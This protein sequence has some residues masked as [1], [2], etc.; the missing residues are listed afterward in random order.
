MF[1]GAFFTFWEAAI[2]LTLYKPAL[3]ELWF[4]QKLCEDPE[5]MSYNRAWGGTIPFP[6]TRWREYHDKWVTRA[7][8]YFRFYRYLRH[9]ALGFVGEAAYRWDPERKIHLANIIVLAEYRRRGFG[10]TGLA[11]LC[12]A[13]KAHGVPV[14][15]DD[16][17]AD[18]PSVGLFLKNG[19]Q[20]ESGTD[21]A[22]TVK[23]VL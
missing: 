16:I 17:A 10:G 14:L 1:S 7:D 19:F 8:E 3:E 2:L 18:N 13:A 20:V 22:V 12:D 21:E 15:Y 9:D 11:L 23:K 6:E 4:R 5:T